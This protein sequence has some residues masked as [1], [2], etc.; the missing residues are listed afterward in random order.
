MKVSNLPEIPLRTYVNHAGFQ[1][2]IHDSWNPGFLV[3]DSN[4]IESQ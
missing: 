1:A 3:F 2:I 4:L